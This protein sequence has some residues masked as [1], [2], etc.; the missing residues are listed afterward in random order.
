M[1]MLKFARPINISEIY[2]P[3]E[4]QTK[5]KNHHC[6]NETRILY[7]TK[8]ACQDKMRKKVKKVKKVKIVENP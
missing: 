5:K 1:T 6:K 3:K 2:L 8:K 4:K 7:R